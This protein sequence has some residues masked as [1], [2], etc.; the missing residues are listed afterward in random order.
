MIGVPIS[1]KTSNILKKNVT[2]MKLKKKKVGSSGNSDIMNG[3]KTILVFGVLLIISFSWKDLSAQDHEDRIQPY[4]KNS[5]YWQYK[6]DPV[7]L[8]GGTKD[9]N[10]FQIPNLKE[11][12]EELRKSGGNY[13]RNTMSDRRDGGFEEYPFQKKPGGTYDLDQWNDEYWQRFENMLRLTSE[14]DIIVQIEVWDRFD[15]SRENW[16]LHPYNPANNINY[17]YEESGFRSEYP[18]HPGANEQPFFFTT[19]DQQNNETILQYQQKFVNKLLDHALKYPNVLYCIDNETSGEEEWAVYWAEFIRDRAESENQ[20]V[21]I[22]EMWDDWD[23]TAEEHRR[24]LDHPER[25]DFVDVSQ[26]NHQTDETHWQNFLWV[27]DFIKNQPR[28]I[29]SVK[30]YGADAGRHGGDNMDAVEKFWRLIFAGAASARFHRPESGLGLQELSKNQIR[31]ARMFLDEFDI[32]NAEPDA[33]HQYLS[34]REEDEAY[35]TRINGDQYA[36][37]FT[38]GGD[39]KVERPEG[40]ESWR[41]RW[42]EL[43]KSNWTENHSVDSRNSFRLSAPGDGLWIALIQKEV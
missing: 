3:I 5:Y 10:L 34:G 18:E 29:N 19:P 8:L 36:I 22:T 30:I 4:K 27:R 39:V 31:S 40:D 43:S 1:E 13:I 11:H 12:L 9:D 7:I 35:L 6:G 17:S 14:M 26:N 21:H 32:F 25:F 42:L 38:N 37:F 41:V 24:T 15:Y 28:P 2:L 33:E 20:P 23:L 16:P